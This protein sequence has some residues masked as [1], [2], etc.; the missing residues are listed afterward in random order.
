MTRTLVSLADKD[1]RAAKKA[2]KREGIS[3]AEYMRRALAVALARSHAGPTGGQAG[4]APAMPWMRHA[5]CLRSGD[6]HSSETVD[7]VVYGRERP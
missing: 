3:F 4:E 2:A 1:Y 7:E 6:P 5:G